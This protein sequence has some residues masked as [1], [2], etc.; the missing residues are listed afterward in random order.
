MKRIIS[1]RKATSTTAGFAL[2][3]VISYFIM[4]RE[5]L[6]FD[7]VVREAIYDLRGD[8]LTAFFT[9]VTCLG[10]WQT[11]TLI[12]FLFLLIPHMRIPFGI[13]LSIS[14]ILATFIQ[15][16]LKVF[17]HRA[18]PTLVLHLIQQGGYSFPSGHSFTILVFYGMLIFLCRQKIKNR[19]LAN[20]V[21]VLLSCLI[22]LIGLS[23]IYL[24]VH[25]PTDVLGGWALGIGVLMLLI[26]VGPSL[27]RKY[28]N[29]SSYS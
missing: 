2:F 14:A 27:Q 19:T 12:C 21:T 5:T 26:T 8:G 28:W 25:Y 23:R 1:K 13:P 22:F 6:V 7:T 18:R 11:I 10:N 16:A 15:K 4:T 3:A 20:L 9:M 24:G 17:F 29:S